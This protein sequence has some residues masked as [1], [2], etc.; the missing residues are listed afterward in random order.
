MKKIYFAGSIRG[1]RDDQELY[2]RIIGHLMKYGEVLTEHIGESGISPSGEEH[3]SDREIYDRD[4]EWL[5][6]SEVIVAEVSTPSLGVGFE[7]GQALRGGKRILC[8]YRIGSSNRLSAMIAGCPDVTVREYGALEDATQ[9]IHE[10][11]R[12]HSV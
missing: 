12:N 8:L 10:F 5:I 9:I 11:F 7:I 1:G 6:S 3:M 2:S 4:M